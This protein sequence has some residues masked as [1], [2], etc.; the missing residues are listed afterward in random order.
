MTAGVAGRDH[1]RTMAP[2][3]ARAASRVPRAVVVIDNVR[4][5]S[6][7]NLRVAQERV[8][9]LFR[10][11]EHEFDVEIRVPPRLKP[12]ATQPAEL[13]VTIQ[14]RDTERDATAR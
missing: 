6:L 10:G 8:A 4:G 2:R 13:A 12:W 5:P 3:P 14:S 1:S 11:G 9:H 7:P